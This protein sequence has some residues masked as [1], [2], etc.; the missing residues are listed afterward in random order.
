MVY[1]EMLIKDLYDRFGL[2]DTTAQWIEYYLKNRSQKLAIDD[3][4]NDLGVT[5]KAV[6]LTFGVPHGSVL[7]P[8]LFTLYGIPLTAI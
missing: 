4:G 6:T 8:I 3:L 2:R 5:S 1:H 7:G